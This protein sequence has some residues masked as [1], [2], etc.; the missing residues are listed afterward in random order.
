ML[1]LAIG[2]LAAV[3]TVPV[4]DGASI[5]KAIDE[6]AAQGGGRVVVPAGEYRSPS[7]RLKSNV[8]LH[9]AKGALLR[10]GTRSEDYF[11]FPVDV[12][13]VRPEKSGRV[14]I[15]AWD[16]ENIAITGEGIIDGRAKEFFSRTESEWNFTWPK[17]EAPRP[18]MVQFVRCRNIRLEG[19]TFED[20]P[21]W[22][23]LIRLCENLTVDNVFVNAD[24]R[25]I[26][27]DG[28]DL[29]GCRHVKS[30]TRASTRATTA[31]SYARCARR[32]ATS[33]SS[34]RTSR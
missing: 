30:G 17:P 7:L 25:V 9:L 11:D 6:V 26:N 1:S 14:F 24:H 4:G 28:I 5:Q 33:G 19:V 23:M 22:T 10:G 2:L 31:S 21:G 27:S 16:A 20:S 18:R 3:V 15:Y 34:A 13:A 32:A 8:E 12:C 29:D